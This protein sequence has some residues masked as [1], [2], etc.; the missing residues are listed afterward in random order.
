MEETLL[1]PAQVADRLQVTEQTIYDWLREGKLAGH[2]LGRLWRVRPK[3]LEAFLQ[4][5]G[6]TKRDH[7][8]PSEEEDRAWLG[9][10]VGGPLPPYEWGSEGPPKGKPVRYVPGVGLVVEGGREPRAF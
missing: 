4:R 6:R 9:A 1:S 5:A 8:V 2:K 7:G 10:D 3:D